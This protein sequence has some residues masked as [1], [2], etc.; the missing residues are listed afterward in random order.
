MPVTAHVIASLRGG[1]NERAPVSLADDECVVARNVEW[2]RSPLGERRKG[3]VA[4]NLTGS[5]LDGATVTWL[6]RHLPTSNLEDAQLWAFG[7]QGDHDASPTPVLAYKDTAWHQV[8]MPDPPVFDYRSEFEIDGQSL[9]GKLFIAYR[10]A[11]DRLHVFDPNSSTT[12]LRRAGIGGTEIVPTAATFGSGTFGGARYYRVRWARWDAVTKLRSE[13]TPATVFYPPGTGQGARITRPAPPGEG[14]NLW[15]LEASLNNADWYRIA[16]LALATTTADDTTPYTPGYAITYPLVEDI[17]DYSVIPSGRYLAADEDRLLIAGNHFDPLLASRIMW[18][19]VYAG[20]GVGN[21]ERLALDSNPFLDLD[22]F[23]GGDIT[24]ISDNVNG[25]TYVTKWRAIYQLTRTGVRTRAYEAIAVTKERGGVHKSMVEGFNQAGL[26]FLF[27]ID[28]EVGPIHIGG[29]NGVVACGRDL[30]ETWPRFHE[31]AIVG[32]RGVYYAEKE[33][34]HWWIATEDAQ[35][36]TLRIVLHH[37]LMRQGQEG[38]RGGLALWDGPSARTW[39]VCMFADNIDAATERSRYLKPFMS[40]IPFWGG[41]IWKTDTGDTDNTHIYTATLHTKAF[42]KTA[43]LDHFEVGEGALMATAGAGVLLT[44]A[45]SGHRADHAVIVKTLSGISLT[46]G[47]GEGDIRV[48]RM[49][50]NLGLAEMQTVAIDVSDQ[51]VGPWQLDLLSLTI[52][53]GQRA[54]Q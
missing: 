9:H 32:A 6:Y 7:W 12:A 37:N 22:N 50:D 33:Q 48:V 54:R 18:T 15:E 19:P 26:P 13:P 11:V 44:V 2:V 52:T 42:A 27:A 4:I 41:T 20:T 23:E 39:A 24:D 10:S 17:G 45:L 3:A 31:D 21:D 40:A 46:P 25:Y 49:L 5:G 28:P 36:P 35:E 38:S 34:I 30:I 53:L 8:T 47:P 14:E 29:P 43:L 16:A 1:L 51:G